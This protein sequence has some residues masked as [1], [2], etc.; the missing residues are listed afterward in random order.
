M[1]ISD[2]LAE[3]NAGR[4][5]DFFGQPER[6]AIMAFAGDVYVGFEARSLPEESLHFAQNHVRILSGLYGLLRP[7]DAIRPYRLEMGTPWAP[8]AK[9]LYRYWGGRIAAL[10]ADDMQAQGTDILVNL[11]SQE[12]WKAAKEHMPPQIRVIN[13]DFREQGPNGLRFNSFGAKRAR[14]MMARYI[15]EHNL[16][17]AESLKSFDSD[18]YSYDQEAS[19]ETMWRFVHR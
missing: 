6:P 18:G 12:Y 14:G 11:A 7:F 15:C 9:N 4:Y 5:A 8:K 3:L 16:T 10:I 19:S 2:A 1:H 13:I 17:D